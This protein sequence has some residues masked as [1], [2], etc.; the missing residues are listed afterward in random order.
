M[1]LE[2]YMK[3]RTVKCIIYFAKKNE[4]FVC[5]TVH[6]HH[7]QCFIPSFEIVIF[8]FSIILNPI[9]FLSCCSVMILMME[10]FLHLCQTV[11]P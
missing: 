6:L 4:D 10:S 8:V 11:S 3:D 1:K 5:N 2:M 7:W 9:I